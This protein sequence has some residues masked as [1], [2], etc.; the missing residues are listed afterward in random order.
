MEV[1]EAIKFFK[2]AQ[3]IVNERGY[4]NISSERLLQTISFLQ[5]GN[6]YKTLLEEI[7]NEFGNGILENDNGIGVQ[8]KNLIEILESKY[9]P[10]EGR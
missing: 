3:N 10:E 8:L 7:K 6:K 2:G 5:E 4:I 9:F 1:K